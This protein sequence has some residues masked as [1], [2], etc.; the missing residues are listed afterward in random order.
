MST[1]YQVQLALPDENATAVINNIQVGNELARFQFQWAI[2][3]EE[4]LNIILDYIGTKTKSD[5][6]ND[7]GTFTYSYDYLAYY[8]ELAQMTDEELDTWLDTDPALPNSILNSPRPSQLSMLRQRIEESKALQPVVAQYKEV[9]KWQFQAIYKNVVTVGY[10]EPG[11]W[12]RNQDPEMRFRFI[13]D[14]PYI[15][16]SD[17]NNVT[18]EFEVNDGS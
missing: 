14:L 2:A 7:H 15:G 11:G 13:S 9:V 3:S 6:L 17:F 1:I 12:Y 5:P 8:M 4:Q 10:I 18:L 16:R